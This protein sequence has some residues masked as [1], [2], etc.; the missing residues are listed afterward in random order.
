MPKSL[1]FSYIRFSSAAQAEGDSLRRQTDRTSGY[2]KLHGLRLDET[3]TLRDLGVSAFKGKNAAV[4]NFRTFLDAVKTGKVPEGSVLIVESFDRISRQGI[5]EGYDLI[6]G[7]LKAGVKI[8]TLSPEREFDVSATKSLS[9]GAL[10]IQLILERAAEESERKSER[11]G[12]AWKKKREGAAER[13]LTKR[14]P[15]WVKYEDG[16]LTLDAAKVKIIKRLVRMAVGGMGLT[17]IAK[18][19]NTEKVPLLGRTSIDG[20]TVVWSASGVH[21]LLTSR[22]LLGE[23]QPHTGSGWNR[24]PS[25]APVRDYYPRVI[26][27]DEFAAVQ[28]ALHT[29]HRIGRGRPGKSISLFA[30]L[31]KD[32]RGGGTIIARHVVGREP[33]LISV[34]A[35]HGRGGQ[36]SCFPLKPLEEAIRS[37]L[38]EVKVEELEPEGPVVSRLAA[39][40]ARRTEIEELLVKWRAKMNR[41]ELVDIVADELAKLE[42]ARKDNEM[43]LSDAERD[44]GTTLAG[45]MR[46][47]K[48][49]GKVLDEEDNDANRLRCQAAIRGAVQSV[50]CLFMP[51]R[52]QRVAVVQVWFKGGAHRDYLIVHRAAG[53]SRWGSWSANTEAKSLASTG[54]DPC[55]LRNPEDAKELERDLLRA[56][57]KTSEEKK[58]VKRGDEK[59]VK[60]RKR[61]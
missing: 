44:S 4:G 48:T 17:G 26:S 35:V 60:V 53:K 45:A 1:A 20:T 11:V 55:D 19:M 21:K 25:G 15:A 30:G 57:A 49:V 40:R 23:Y 37:Q 42:E 29:R 50:Y 46:E 18:T 31:L 32:A 28:T 38:E 58:P 3:L 8:V 33:T 16:R 61:K 54:V 41:P 22:S 27:D 43:E 51:G 14:V 5:D 34:N 9:K 39:L 6:K 10:E 52:G 36:W 13:P 7:I 12:A 56:L 59:K 24:K 47:L 2:C